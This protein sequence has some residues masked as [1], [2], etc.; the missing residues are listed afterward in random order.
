[1]KI[2]MVCLGNICR[3]P[4]AEAVLQQKASQAGLNWK[5]DS[6]GTYDMP[7]GKAPHPLSQKVALVHGIDICSQRSRRFT[8]DD[9]LNYDRLYALSDDVMEEM[10]TIG[11]NRYDPTK[12]AL[13]MNEVFPG[14][15]LNVDDPWG[16]SESG[17]QQAYDLIAAACDSIIGRYKNN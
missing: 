11:A 5:I 7:M 16:G 9:F 6:A 3:S 15:N 14:E 17:F 1:M 13:L 10:K 2:L 4:L 8:A 12:T